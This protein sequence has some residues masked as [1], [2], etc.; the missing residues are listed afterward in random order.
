MHIVW[1]VLYSHDI[2]PQHNKK[3]EYNNDTSKPYI[4]GSVLERLNSIANTLE[5]HLSCTNPSISEFECNIKKTTHISTSFMSYALFIQSFWEKNNHT[6]HNGVP[7]TSHEFPCSASSCSHH[8]QNGLLGS[9][10]YRYGKNLDS[11]KCTSW[12]RNVFFLSY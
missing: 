12:D 5:L 8:I 7:I 4:D 1:D 11:S 9:N 6:C 10:L 2:L 3:I